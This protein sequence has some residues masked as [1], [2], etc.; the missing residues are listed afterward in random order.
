M[1]DIRSALPTASAEDQRPVF[2]LLKGNLCLEVSAIA[3]IDLDYYI[4]GSQIRFHQGGHG[5]RLK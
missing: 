1:A 5:D 4:R 2:E 3:M